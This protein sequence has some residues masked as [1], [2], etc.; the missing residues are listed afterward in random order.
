VQQLVLA[1]AR[2]GLLQSIRPQRRLGT[3]QSV[4][5]FST[6]LLLKVLALKPGNSANRS[7]RLVAA[8]RTRF[9]RWKLYLDGSYLQ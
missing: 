8:N 4:I 5:S 2:T 6:Y 9:R 7:M 3:A 1:A